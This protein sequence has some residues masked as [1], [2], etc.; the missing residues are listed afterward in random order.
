[1]TASFAGLRERLN[2]TPGIDPSSQ[3]Y[4]DTV[5]KIGIT[6]AAQTAATANGARTAVDG[7]AR[8]RLTDAVSLGKGLPA[9]AS[10]ALSGAASN[11]SNLANAN[12]R[13]NKANAD[14]MFGFARAVGD[15]VSSPTVKN[16]FGGGL[17]SDIT[18]SFRAEDPYKNPGY[19]GGDIGE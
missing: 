14:Q 3:K 8:A 9:N 1:M 6:E 12:E 2:S 17:G 18:K 4:L 11:Y 5:S 15:V 16:W 10:A 13:A 7:E 19:F